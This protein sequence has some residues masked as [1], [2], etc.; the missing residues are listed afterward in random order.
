MKTMKKIGIWMDHSTA[1]LMEFSPE[2]MTTN[3]IESSFTN[4]VKADSQSKG[5]HLMHNKEQ[6]Q[7]AGYYHELAAIIKDYDAVLLFG[8]TNAKAELFNLLKGDH[9]FDKVHI[10]V[11]QTDKMTDNQ[12]HAFVRTHFGL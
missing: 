7:Q 4:Q 12:Q 6:Q 3:T 5:E 10:E 1:H 8:P 9:H 2:D 11:K